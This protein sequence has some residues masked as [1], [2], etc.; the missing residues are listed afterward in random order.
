MMIFETLHDS[1]QRGELLCVDGGLC[2]WH[3]RRDGQLTIREIISTR[4]GAG[5]QMLRRLEYTPGA[6]S[7]FAKCPVDLPANTWYTR[8]GFHVERMERTD[9]GRNLLHWRKP[10][11]HE[12]RRPNAGDLEVIFCADGNPRMAQIAIDAGLLY[13]ARLPGSVA[14]RPYFADQEWKRPNRAAY[15]ARLAKHRPHMATVLDLER[16]AQ[17]GE[18]LAWAEEAARYVQRVVII[19]KAHGIIAHLPTSIAGRPIRLGYSVPTRYGGTPVQLHEFAAW[20]GDGVHLL[21]GS[22]ERQMHIYRALG[23]VRSVDTNYT[24]KIALENNKYW[25]GGWVALESVYINGPCEAF[26]RSCVNVMNAWRD[27]VAQPATAITPA[28]QYHLWDAQE[29]ERAAG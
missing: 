9:S 27:V 13:G 19:P 29:F 4:K 25:A 10:L 21:G 23:N 7:L 5:Y 16:Y 2:H 1:A 3:L 11:S 12:A 15:M 20:K 17:L 28:R 6:T 22:P 14:F 26:R 8:Q 18:V 24:A